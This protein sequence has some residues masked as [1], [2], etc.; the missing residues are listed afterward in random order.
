MWTPVGRSLVI[1]T[2][3]TWQFTLQWRH[4]D[5]GGASNH[6]PHGCLPNRLSRHRS[7][8]TSKL[9]VTGLCV[10]NSPGPVNSPHKGPVTRKMVP[11]DDVIMMYVRSDSRR[12]RWYHYLWKFVLF[13]F[14]DI[15][16]ENTAVCYWYYCWSKV[17][18]FD[19]RIS[20]PDW[21]FEAICY[22]HDNITLFIILC[23]SLHCLCLLV[24]LTQTPQYI[25]DVIIGVRH[26]H[27]IGGYL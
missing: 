17:P 8:K 27:L 13:E 2:A 25:G 16:Y 3:L 7:K 23:G 24:S 4:S 5:H 22:F 20:V 10:G 11:F 26:R 21:E 6:Q 9:R 14:V 1:Y 15:S 12:C 18:T 19:P